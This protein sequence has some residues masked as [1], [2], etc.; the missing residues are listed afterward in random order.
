[1]RRY[2]SL[3]LV[4]SLSF[5]ACNKNKGSSVD[6]QAAQAAAVAESY[7]GPEEAAARDHIYQL[8]D[9]VRAN[10]EDGDR[11]EQRV[12]AYLHMHR[13]ELIRNARALESTLAAKSG[14]ERTIYE[15]NFS[16]Y[17][18]PALTAWYAQVRVFSEKHPVPYRRI[19]RAFKNMMNRN[20]GVP[21]AP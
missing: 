12:D 4:A 21:P 2:L 1:M 14:E 20:T 13:D 15:E 19:E 7:L 8:A 6:D 17:M 10:M 3:V 9:L 11:A 18:A 5:A 16:N